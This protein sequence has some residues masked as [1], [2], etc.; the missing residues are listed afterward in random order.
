LSIKKEVPLK[1]GLPL[2]ANKPKGFYLFFFFL[3][4]AFLVAFF[5]AGILSFTSFQG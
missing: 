4:L 3:T 2:G 1:A 5:F